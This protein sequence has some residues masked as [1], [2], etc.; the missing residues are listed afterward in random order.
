MGSIMA[1]LLQEPAPPLF[2]FLTALDLHCCAGLS[3][4]GEWGLLSSCSA[5]LLIMVPSL[6]VEQGL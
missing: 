2:F 3:S 1:A 4:R 6:V 5:E